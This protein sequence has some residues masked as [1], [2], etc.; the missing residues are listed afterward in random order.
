MSTRVL[1][2][3]LDSDG[4]VL[5]SGPAVRAVRAGAGHVTM[6]VGP[7]GRAAA[8]LLPEVDD[9]IVW[10]CPWIDPEPRAVE[11]A[12]IAG[13]VR[14][15]NAGGFD[16]ALILTSFH[17]SP[18]PL[19]L[20]LR[21]AGVRRVTAASEDYPGSLLDVRHRLPDSGLHEVQRA[22]STA[23]AAGY[24]LP[25]GD[26]GR[27]R[28]RGPIPDTRHLTGA[29]PYLVLHPGT[30][31][32]AR[33]W[34][35]SRFA[36]LAAALAGNGHRVAVTGAADETALTAHV[37]GAVGRDL[38]GATDLVT[39]AGVLAGARAIVIGNTG[40][41]HLAA[42]V[43]TPVISLFAPTVPAERWAPYADRGV[44]LGDLDI[45]CAG[46]R[47]RRCPVP[48][49]PCLSTVTVS[50]VLAA[51]EAVTRGTAPENLPQEATA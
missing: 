6:L 30:S 3:R 25:V 35:P 46:C 43:G 12:D 26:D 23:A 24:R 51:V 36:A 34:E 22:L 21:L 29:A 16:E 18:L 40:P 7:R 17:Q 33:R 15:L 44:V 20:L 13:L 38:G 11:P 19:A 10:H 4:D 45:D 9:I 27:L 14:R 31:V 8:G 32:P 47:A 5:L 28:I 39:L 42:A 1:V 41:A 2:A 50:D 48:G 49:H 37:A